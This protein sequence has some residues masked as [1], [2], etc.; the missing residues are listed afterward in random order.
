MA[1]K[2][3]SRTPRFT[4]RSLE[5]FI[6]TLHDRCPDP[7]QT[8]WRDVVRR[9]FNLTREQEKSLLEIPE[10]RAKNIQ[11][12][13]SKAAQYIRRGGNITAQIVKRSTKTQTPDRVYDLVIS[14]HK[15]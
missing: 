8:D 12:I 9:A 15:K 2:R 4:A 13:F 14:L 6:E 5:A 3:Q 7:R 1:A 11:R 10:G